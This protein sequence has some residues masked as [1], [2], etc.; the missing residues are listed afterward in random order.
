MLLLLACLLRKQARG[1]GEKWEKKQRFSDGSLRLS[2]KH[3]CVS[4]VLG[5]GRG[6]ASLPDSD[7][8]PSQCPHL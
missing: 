8:S 2:L 6:R 1:H 7:R 4:T 5:P 3:P